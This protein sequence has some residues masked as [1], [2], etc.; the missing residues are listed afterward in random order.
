M[1]RV[2]LALD[3]APAATGDDED[4]ATLVSRFRLAGLPVTA[5]G[6]D[7]ALP[8][9]AIALAARRILAESLTN[10]LRHARDTEEVRV[11]VAH[12]DE[13]LTI[14]VVNSAKLMSLARA[15][16]S[17]PFPCD[18]AILANALIIPKTVPNSPSI[19][20]VFTTVAIQLVPYSSE[21]RMSR[22][23][24]SARSLLSFAIGRFMFCMATRT[25]CGTALLQY[26]G[27]SHRS[28][29]AL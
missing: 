20:A 26:C 25:S 12:S 5:T 28:A 24:L 1:K 18:A 4:L 14:A 21:A 15:V 23:N 19:G 8:E 11:A 2:L 7:T 6:L 22:S 10:V 17:V 3:D 13:V 16:G 9:A 27:E 29:T